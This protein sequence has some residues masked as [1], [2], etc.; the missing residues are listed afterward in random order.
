MC[1]VPYKSLKEPASKDWCIDIGLDVSR[2][3]LTCH[4][5][6]ILLELPSTATCLSQ[7]SAPPPPS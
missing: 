4:A 5:A 1:T 2:A 7:K 6:C 3:E